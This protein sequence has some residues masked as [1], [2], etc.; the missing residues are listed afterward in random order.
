MV[1]KMKAKKIEFYR[2]EFEVEA[3]FFGRLYLFFNFYKLIKVVKYNSTW[4]VA[5]PKIKV[6]KSE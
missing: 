4:L 3:N 6:V 5:I 1:K 2:P